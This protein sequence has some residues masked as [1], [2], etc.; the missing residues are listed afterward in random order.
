LD[1]GLLFKGR[2]RRFEKTT[3]NTKKRKGEKEKDG[4]R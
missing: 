1:G 3:G 4:E 2:E